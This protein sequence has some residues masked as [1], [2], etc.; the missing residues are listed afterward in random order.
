M[1]GKMPTSLILVRR[2]KSLANIKFN[3]K[4]YIQLQISP[5]KSLSFEIL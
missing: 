4:T 3:A 2:K 1:L 5:P